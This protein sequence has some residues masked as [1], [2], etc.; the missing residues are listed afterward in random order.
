MSSAVDQMDDTEVEMLNQTEL[1]Q[2]VANHIEITGSEP[3]QPCYPSPEQMTAIFNKVV[4]R[5]EAPYAD[6]SVLF[7]SIADFR[8][9]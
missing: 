7:L 1:D 2:M 5:G 8:S 4:I 3:L 6:F 9:K